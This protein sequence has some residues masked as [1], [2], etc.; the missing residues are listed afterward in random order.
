M[1]KIKQFTIE[2]NITIPDCFIKSNNYKS[3]TITDIG[4][5]N[6]PDDKFKRAYRNRFSANFKSDCATAIRCEENT[7]LAFDFEYY[8][9][10]ANWTYF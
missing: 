6:S 5:F 1:T 10:T 9:A 3:N 7:L 8:F 2:I 4:N